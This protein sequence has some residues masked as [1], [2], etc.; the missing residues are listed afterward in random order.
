MTAVSLCELCAIFLWPAFGGCN[1]VGQISQVAWCAAAVL[2]GRFQQT[3]RLAL[4][5]DV[6]IGMLCQQPGAVA[7]LRPGRPAASSDNFFK[8]CQ[9]SCIDSSPALL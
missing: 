6:V 4:E 7:T 3:F 2:D 8:L 9:I 5:C 1:T